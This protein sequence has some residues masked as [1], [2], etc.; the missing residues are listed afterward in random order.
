MRIATLSILSVLAALALAACGGDDPLSDEAYFEGLEA[1]GAQSDAQAEPLF[2]PF[3]D[4]T[5][6]DAETAA[7]FLVGYQALFETASAGTAALVPPSDLAAAHDASLEA[8][9]AVIDEI[10]RARV[11]VE[12][13][14][15][16]SVF[17][18]LRPAAFDDFARVCATFEQLAVDRGFHLQL[19]CA[20]E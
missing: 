2:E 12:A 16:D 6:P 1:V 5:P 8:M 13:G 20:D 10:E 15:V 7:A 9:D 14:E 3:A 19:S 18:E 17:V 4:D 11:R